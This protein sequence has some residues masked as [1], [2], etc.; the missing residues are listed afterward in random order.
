MCW[1]LDF[2]N[3]LIEQINSGSDTISNQDIDVE[4]PIQLYE[5]TRWNNSRKAASCLPEKVCYK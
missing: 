4:P 2:P 1:F 5:A 3:D